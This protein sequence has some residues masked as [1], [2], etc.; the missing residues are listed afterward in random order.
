MREKFKSI[1]Y[2]EEIIEDENVDYYIRCLAIISLCE[3]NFLVLKI[4]PN[5]KT[6]EK[7]VTLVDNLYT[8]SQEQHAFIWLIESL[9]LLSKLSL[10]NGDIETSETRLDQALKIAKEKQIQY[11]IK[12]VEQ[13][14]SSLLADLKKWQLLISQNASLVEKLQFSGI[15]NYIKTA[16]Q[17]LSL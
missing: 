15:E 3:L 10:L 4:T 5:Q 2:F 7:T 6:L 9:I 1:T 8:K 17:K 13:E 16:K 12:K 11:L 14:Q